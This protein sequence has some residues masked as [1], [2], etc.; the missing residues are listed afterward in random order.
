[1]SGRIAF[2]YDSQDGP[3]ES[4]S[5]GRGLDGDQNTAVRT[6]LVFEPSDSFSAYVK[7]EY[8][9]DRDE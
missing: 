3:T 6:S 9:A 4:I 7:L 2:N 1:M 5:T 8:S